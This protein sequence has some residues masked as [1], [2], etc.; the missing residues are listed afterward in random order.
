MDV[1]WRLW[2]LNWCREGRR[3][4][5]AEFRSLHIK[6][7]RKEERIFEADIS[8]EL[9]FSPTAPTW[10]GKQSAPFRIVQRLSAIAS[11]D[12]QLEVALV[13]DCRLQGK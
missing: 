10:Q 8:I 4:L 13:L 3:N 5:A 12:A 1:K 11:N 9:V 6:V 7:E 2:L